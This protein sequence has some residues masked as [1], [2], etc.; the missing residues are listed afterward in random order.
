MK[1]K[2]KEEGRKKGRRKEE[3]NRTRNLPGSPMCSL[4][5]VSGCL[6]TRAILT[7]EAE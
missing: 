5:I 6:G 2:R 7:R 4:S 3:Q 1:E